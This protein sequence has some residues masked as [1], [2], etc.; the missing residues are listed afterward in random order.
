MSQPIASISTTTVST[1]KT[2]DTFP[3]SQGGG[4]FTLS[5]EVKVV[6]SEGASDSIDLSPDARKALQVLLSG[7]SAGTGGTTEATA[8]APD[9]STTRDS[10]E[11][12]LTTAHAS[13]SGR[14]P[15]YATA[16]DNEVAWTDADGQSGHLEVEEGWSLTTDLQLVPLSPQLQANAEAGPAADATTVTVSDTDGS[17]ASA[18]LVETHDSSRSLDEGKAALMMLTANSASSSWYGSPPHGSPVSRPS[19]SQRA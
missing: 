15:D 18:A 8:S 19:L 10:I 4:T 16:S 9:G 7:G 14:Q 2:S 1:F 5:K 13:T 17:L 3:A 11:I 12:S 6:S